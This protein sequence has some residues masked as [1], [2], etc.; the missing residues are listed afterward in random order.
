MDDGTEGDLAQIKRVAH[1]GL[2][3]LARE[4]LLTDLQ[5]GGSD[6]VALLTVLV[7]Y[8]GSSDLI[9]FVISK[10]RGEP[11]SEKYSLLKRI[12]L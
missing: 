9:Y 1:V 2:D 6:D 3:T 4:D 5:A 10:K 7:E 8:E 12:F 11:K